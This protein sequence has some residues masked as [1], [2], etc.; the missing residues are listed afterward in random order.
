LAADFSKDPNATGFFAP[1]R[2]EGDILDCEVEGEIPS[3]IKGSFYRSCLDRRYP[4]MYANDTPYNSDGAVDL[5]RIANGSVDFKS[6]YVRTA[7][8]EAEARA[9]RAL[10]GLY[11]NRYTF[12]P[13]VRDL[14]QNT[15]NTTP[16][17][18][19][20]RLFSMKEDSPPM[21]IDPH[22]LATLGEWD[23]HGEMNAKTFTA[24]PKIDPRTGEMIAFSYEAKG[25]ATDDLAVFVF[26]KTGRQ[27]RSWWFKSPVVSMMHD[28]AITDKHIILPTTGMT[29][30][31]ERLKRGEIHWGYDPK[32]PAHVAIIPRD[33]DVK[34]I[35]WFKGTPQQA[36]LVHTTNARTEGN[37]VILDAPVAGGNFHPYFPSIDG[38]PYNTAARHPTIR[39]WTFDLDSKNDTWQEEILFGGMKVTSFVR[40]DDRYLTH[41]FRY[42][43]MMLTDP[44]R[45]LDEKRFGNLAAR[46]SNLWVRLDHATGATTQLFA[47]EV[48][49]FSE[50]QFIPR[51]KDAPEGDG[52]LIG[53][54][55]NFEE[56]RSDIVIVDALRLEEGPVARIRLPFRLHTQV[57]GWWASA[58]DLPFPVSRG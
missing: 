53:A 27:T 38:S 47:G 3:G 23:F 57:H 42:S 50:P 48:H 35:R 12:D 30:S 7:R 34:D 6:R 41:P 32:M 40:M 45:P 18:H 44:S 19:G 14:S 58:D 26:D 31:L 1:T 15:A 5:F 8:F 25:D 54:M 39:R 9:R 49:G 10:F 4:P 11:R 36:M 20:G 52:Y 24:H 2:F 56:M 43:Y 51:A 22:T 55:N 29:T 17:L 37:K 33:G 28:M 21:Q 13:S 46:V 16:M